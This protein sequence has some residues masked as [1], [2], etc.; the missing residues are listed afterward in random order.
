ML[1]L[2]TLLVPPILVPEPDLHFSWL[3]IGVVL[4]LSIY[5]VR[6]VRDFFCVQ[7]THLA[8]G[9][10]RDRNG[11]NCDLIVSSV[12]TF[13]D[14]CSK[15]GDDADDSLERSFLQIGVA[16][17]WPA[18]FAPMPPILPNLQGS[19]SHTFI[20]NLTI[21][22]SEIIFVEILLLEQNILQD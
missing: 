11:L 5:L 19:H 14:P 12:I 17:E 3:S 21:S 8:D 10:K 6:T 22:S 15:T 18:V 16:F 4:A 2:V 20:G 9:T 1:Y 13:P 7:F